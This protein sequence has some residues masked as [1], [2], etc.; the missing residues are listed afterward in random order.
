ML[1]AAPRLVAQLNWLAL[2][3]GFVVTMKASWL[4]MWLG[5]VRKMSVSR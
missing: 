4:A 1:F 3:A 5:L 2:L